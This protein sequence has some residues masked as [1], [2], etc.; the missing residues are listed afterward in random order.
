MYK[1]LGYF[2]N[3]KMINKTADILRLKKLILSVRFFKL[4]IILVLNFKAIPFKKNMK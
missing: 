3:N 4:D 1:K 2:K